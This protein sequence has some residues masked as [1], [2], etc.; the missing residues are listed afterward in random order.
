MFKIEIALKKK[1][2]ESPALLQLKEE[3]AAKDDE[4]AFLR[5]QLAQCCW[6]R[7]SAC[8]AVGMRTC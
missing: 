5:A 2:A 7:C 1:E 3:N 4:I 6:T 8:C